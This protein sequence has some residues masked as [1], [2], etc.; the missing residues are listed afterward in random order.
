[1]ALLTSPCETAS[2]LLPRNLLSEP[3]LETLGEEQ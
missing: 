2:G 1:M 3:P